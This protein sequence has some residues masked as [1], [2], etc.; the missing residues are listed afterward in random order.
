MRRS[1]Q[2]GF[3]SKGPVFL[4]M[5][6]LSSGLGGI[7]AL[8]YSRQLGIQ[9][10]SVMGFILITAITL[11]YL[12]ASGIT[13]TFRQLS[14]SPE[15]QTLALT[16]VVLLLISTSV[17]ISG[18]SFGSLLI[19]SHIKSHLPIS[20]LILGTGFALMASLDYSS[21]NILIGLGK[22]RTAGV[23]EVIVAILQVS[24]YFLLRLLSSYSLSTC[25]LIAFNLSYIFSVVCTFFIVVKRLSLRKLGNFA[26]LYDFL[27]TVRHNHVYS[28]VSGLA[29]YSDKLIVAWFM[30]LAK[31]T[32]YSVMA[33]LINYVRFLPEALANLLVAGHGKSISKPFE[34][35]R[36]GFSALAVL[37]YGF[38]G[39]TVYYFT[40]YWFGANWL[41]PL[42]IYYLVVFQEILRAAYLLSAAT[43][44]RN[45]GDRV[46]SNISL[47]LITM[48]LLLAIIGVLILGIYGVVLAQVLTYLTSSLL[49]SRELRKISLVKPGGSLL[50]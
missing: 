34:S 30:P 36:K 18:I 7:F 22:I 15:M 13:L 45:G 12:L 31:F 44:I 17:V 9:N 28:L 41:L 11:I 47:V 25:V 19:Y 26:E 48:Y 29:D 38:S 49:V 5:R 8:I 35:H 6:V 33:G 21:S 20:L 37:L 14:N 27:K 42:A 4:T 23:V 43:L 10:R 39:I 32:Q 2:K 16:R 50:V 24:L 3:L 1:S 46:N 40:K